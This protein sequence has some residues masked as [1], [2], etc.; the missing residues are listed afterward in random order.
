MMRKTKM[1]ITRTLN[2]ARFAPCANGAGMLIT[3]GAAARLARPG[4]MVSISPA[5]GNFSDDF[6]PAPMNR[7]N[8]TRREIC[9]G[10]ISQRNNQNHLKERT[11]SAP[12]Q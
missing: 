7:N 2:K 9:R 8:L 4:G 12:N 11:P 5:G 10:K 6:N 1:K 3:S